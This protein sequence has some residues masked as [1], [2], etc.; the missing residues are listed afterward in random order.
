MAHLGLMDHR[1]AKSY[2]LTTV[3]MREFTNVA[4]RNFLIRKLDNHPGRRAGPET[5]I[6]L[7]SNA[8]GSGEHGSAG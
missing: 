8:F 6:V 1:R 3:V 2:P 4:I 7:P 5:R